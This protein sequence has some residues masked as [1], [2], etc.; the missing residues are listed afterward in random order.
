MKVPV[1][2]ELRNLLNQVLL[3]LDGQNVLNLQGQR[4][5]QVKGRQLVN[6]HG[7]ILAEVELGRVPDSSGGTH[8]E[9]KGDDV[10]NRYGQ[11]IAI[12][13]GGTADEKAVLAAAFETFC[14]DG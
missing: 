9:V 6:F 4:I 8:L 14:T 3:R 7:Q 2:I 5:A 13:A 1:M 12:V 11:K 10:F